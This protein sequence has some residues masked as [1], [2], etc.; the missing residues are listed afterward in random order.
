MDIN[1]FSR[2]L[3]SFAD[4]PAD[5]NLEQGIVVAQI[6]DEIIDAR[7]SAKAAVICGFMKRGQ[8]PFER[9]VGSL[10]E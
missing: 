10:I 3:T 9:S 5:V 1:Q 2:V 7:N 8:N 4:T 6:R